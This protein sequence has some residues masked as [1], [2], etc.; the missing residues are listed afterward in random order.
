MTENWIATACFAGAL[1]HSLSVSFFEKL[2]R[3]FNHR[4]FAS[5]VFHFL[6][7]IEI[8]FGIWAAI[9]VGFLMLNRG[10]TP[11]LDWLE[12]K[13][14]G[15]AIFVFVIMAMSAT[16]PI[17]T[18]AENII[19]FISRIVPLPRVQAVFLATLII[20]PLLGSFVTEPAAMT[21]SALLLRKTIFTKSKNLK[22]LYST[23]ATLFVNVSIGG[24]LTSFAAPPVL[25]VA[26]PWGWDS[27]FMFGHFG[28][29]AIFAVIVNA[30]L[31]LWINRK[32]LENMEPARL[33][34]PEY[35]HAQHADD[36]RLWIQ[37]V[38]AGFIMLAI[39][40]VHHPVFLVGHFLFFLGFV[41]ATSYA[42][43]DLKM[44]ES[45][46]V[47]FFLAG[48]VVLTSEQSWWLKPLLT[49]MTDHALYFGAAGL[50][51]ITDNAALTSLAAQVPDLSDAA[52]Y[53]V[54]AGSVVGGGLTLIANAPNPAG[55][56]ILRNEF[57]TLGLQPFRFLQWALP[58]TVIAA[59]FYLL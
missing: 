12:A 43:S 23:I 35:T 39:I 38:N 25:M 16:K 32:T 9:Y 6:G 3:K 21:V 44:R 54:V 36:S 40:G 46:L 22:L 49:S 48:L 20:G 13:N 58:P 17:L 57:G 14:F 1:I 47:S 50:T 11:A 31:V 55:Y 19:S 41:T 18:L 53:F 42:Q 33:T 4:T 34:T 29:K 8:V 10:L 52:K 2:S 30:V 37:I 56:A 7:E 51:A 15:E 59:L 5:S 28:W 24:T 45:L 27:G 26:R